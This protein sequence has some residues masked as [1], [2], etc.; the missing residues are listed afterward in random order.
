MHTPPLDMSPSNRLLGG[1]P[2][3]VLS[4][5]E[6]ALPRIQ[7][8]DGPAAGSVYDLAI[9][10]HAENRNR[11]W[12]QPQCSRLAELWILQNQ[13]VHESTDIHG[14]SQSVEDRVESPLE[15]SC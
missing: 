4:C 8:E 12:K 1:N 5:R 13:S 2:H 3:G 11:T 7:R 10:R 14:W 6:Q 9:L 15:L